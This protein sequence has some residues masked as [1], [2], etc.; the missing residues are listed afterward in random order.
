MTD[1]IERKETDTE[2][3]TGYLVAKY[4]DKEV[5]RMYMN[6]NKG[7]LVLN[8]DNTDLKEEGYEIKTKKAM[9]GEVCSEVIE[10]K[11]CGVCMFVVTNVYVQ[12]KISY[13]LMVTLRDSLAIDIEYVD[14]TRNAHDFKSMKDVQAMLGSNTEDALYS[15]SNVVV[16]D[17]SG[18]AGQFGYRYMFEINGIGCVL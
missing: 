18:N 13:R 9:D 3:K 15:D 11:H 2:R 7:R 1:T 10:I 14:S 6:G 17:H 4:R 8:E 12:S 5:F 16:E